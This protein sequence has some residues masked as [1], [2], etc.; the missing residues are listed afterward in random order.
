MTAPGVSE[1]VR[2]SRLQGL[3]Q[4]RPNRRTTVS[5][6]IACA[7]PTLTADIEA[8]THLYSDVARRKRRG[9]MQ[10][11]VVFRHTDMRGVGLPKPRHAR[12]ASAVKCSQ[13]KGSLRRRFQKKIVVYF[14]W[15]KIRIKISAFIGLG[16]IKLNTTSCLTT[17]HLSMPLST[18]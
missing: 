5:L 8:T 6:A 4:S 9:L 13:V 11:I 14:K 15:L 7:R 2:T 12:R 3:N 1:R 10:V 17:H 18:G 16:R